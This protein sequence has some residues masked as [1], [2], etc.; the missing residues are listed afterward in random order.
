MIALTAKAAM[1]ADFERVWN[2]VTEAHETGLVVEGKVVRRVKGGVVVDLL[3][4]VE[5]FL[6]GSLLAQRQVQDVDAFL[7]R[8]VQVKILK[9]NKHLRNVVVSRRVVLDEEH[10]RR[11]TATLKDLAKD[12]IREGVINAITDYGVFVDLGGVEGLMHVNDMSWGQVSHPSEICAT[13]DKVRV[14]VLDFDPERERISLGLKQLE[15]CPLE[16]GEER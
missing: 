10:E 9:R 15:P 7:G 2:R 13:G 8:T 4:G 6:P 5:A 1:R 12:Q 14:K 16:G 11:K 3:L